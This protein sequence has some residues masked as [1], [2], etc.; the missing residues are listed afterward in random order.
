[1]VRRVSFGQ[2]RGKSGFEETSRRYVYVCIAIHF[3]RILSSKD[4]TIVSFHLLYLYIIYLIETSSPIVTRCAVSCIHTM[5]MYVCTYNIK[6]SITWEVEEKG[7]NRIGREEA[8]AEQEQ[9]SKNIKLSLLRFLPFIS[10]LQR[11]SESRIRTRVT[12]L[13][14]TKQGWIQLSPV[15]NF[16]P[17]R[18][19]RRLI[20]LETASKL[21]PGIICHCTLMY[22]HIHRQT[23]N[24]KLL[25][26]PYFFRKFH[27][28]VYIFSLYKRIKFL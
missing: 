27:L 17:V 8:A 22:I 28:K 21:S 14:G 10:V 2:N 15:P 12:D 5:C 26:F 1:M 16:L 6:P 23:Q 19:Q 4:Q 20:L 13:R 9:G 18:G 3:C 7:I 25:T 11:H 24:Y